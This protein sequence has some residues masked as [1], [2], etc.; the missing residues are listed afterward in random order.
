VTHSKSFEPLQIPLNYSL[1]LIFGIQWVPGA[2]SLG[3]KRPGREAD[4]SPP[5]PQYVFM[6]WC[7]GKHGD[8]FTLPFASFP[9]PTCQSNKS[10]ASAHVY[11]SVSKSIRTEWITKYTLTTITLVEKQYKGLRRHNSL[12][13]LTK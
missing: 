5:L 4:H 2:S 9:V 6:A 11:E 12:D 13:R 1:H 8:N 3:I 7:L 10:T